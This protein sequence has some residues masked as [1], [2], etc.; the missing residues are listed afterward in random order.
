VLHGS[1]RYRPFPT[2]LLVDPA[3]RLPDSVGF[4]FPSAHAA[5]V[6][7]MAAVAAPLPDRQVPHSGVGRGAA[8]WR[9]RRVPGR[10]PAAG[11]FCR[12]IPRLG[13]RHD[14]PSGVRSPGP[15]NLSGSGASGPGTGRVDADARGAVAAPPTGIVGVRGPDLD[16]RPVTSADRASDAP[17]RGTLLPAAAAA[18]LPGCRG[19]AAA[20][21][22]IPRGRTRSVRD[23][24][25]PTRRVAHTTGRVGLRDRT[26]LAVCWCADT[27]RVAG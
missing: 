11:C 9:G 15:Q 27:S 4:A 16:R 13:R 25:R 20:V 19:R 1:I 12:D 7:A 6:A 23:A 3:A 8:G 5:I 14:L 2:Q 22:H 18:G 17:P 21:D 24:V 26:R 10:S